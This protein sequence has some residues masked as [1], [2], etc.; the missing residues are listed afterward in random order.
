M[1]IKS[2]IRYMEKSME[3]DPNWVEEDWRRIMDLDFMIGRVVH[4]EFEI[5]KDEK[6]TATE[7]M[8]KTFESKEKVWEDKDGEVGIEKGGE[9]GGTERI[10]E[11]GRTERIGEFG[12]TERIGEVGRTER[13]G[14]VGRVIKLAG[15]SCPPACVGKLRELL[16][17]YVCSSGEEYNPRGSIYQ[18]VLALIEARNQP[19][20]APRKAKIQHILAHTEPTNQPILEPSPITQPSEKQ[21]SVV[22]RLSSSPSPTP[23]VRRSSSSLGYR[24]RSRL[25]K[26]M[27]PVDENNV[28]SSYT[29]N[30]AT[31]KTR[32]SDLVNNNAVNQHCQYTA[33]K[34]ANVH[35]QNRSSSLGPY[36][37]RHGLCTDNG[38]YECNYESIDGYSSSKSDES[39]SAIL[40]LENAVKSL[41]KVLEKDTKRFKYENDFNHKVQYDS[42]T[43]LPTTS[44]REL[45]ITPSHSS[46]EL[47]PTPLPRTKSFRDRGVEQGQSKLNP[48]DGRACSAP[49]ISPFF[50][51]RFIQTTR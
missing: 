4:D 50:Y 20:L 29:K 31:A 36:F 28:I 13:I 24:L 43:V 16:L 38:I 5:N 12:R 48:G 19:V 14:E 49:P 3:L 34:M 11:I 2:D 37:P 10:R 1:G 40:Q 17:Q 22:S 51:R 47:P 39:N 41:D 32:I 7:D 27:A 30:P 26:S 9:V 15:S 25:F 33:N 44:L 45:P 23:P 35:V 46:R 8:D 6:D 18:P 42:I 21:C